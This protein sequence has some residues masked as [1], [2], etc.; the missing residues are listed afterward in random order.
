[1]AAALA[2]VLFGKAVV[3]SLPLLVLGYGPRVAAIVGISLAQ[4]GEFAFVMLAQGRAANLVSADVYQVALAA[5]IISM[6]ATPF[7]FLLGH[8]VGDRVAG[9]P[10]GRPRDLVRRSG[11]AEPSR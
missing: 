2:L 1:M 8:A 3:A 9:L 6:T 10:L 4:I 7:L 5:T 11:R